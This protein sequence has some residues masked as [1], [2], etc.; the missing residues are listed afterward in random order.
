MQSVSGQKHLF[1]V[2]VNNSLPLGFSKKSIYCSYLVCPA[3]LQ[4]WE[5]TITSSTLAYILCLTSLKNINKKRFKI[6]I[7]LY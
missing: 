6:I 4:H 7:Y 2:I 3:A 1:E 5:D